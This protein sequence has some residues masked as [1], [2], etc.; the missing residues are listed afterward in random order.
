MKRNKSLSSFI[1]EFLC[2]RDY[3]F[4]YLAFNGFFHNMP[5]DVYLR[6]LYKAMVGKDLD[7]EQ[8]STFNEKLQWLKLFD[9][10]PDY[11]KMVDK[12]LVRQYVIKTIGEKYLIPIVGVW[13]SPDEI[14]FKS[15]PN[16]FVLKCNHNSGTGMCICKD[17]ALL[18]IN[19]VKAE[20]KKGL[21]ED[22]YYQG[23]EWPY[24]DVDR[25]IICEKY[26]T[27]ENDQLSDYKI[28]NFNGVPRVILVCRD[29]FKDSGLTEDFYS[30]K[31]EH[32]DI[33]RPGIPN[34]KQKISKP[35]ELEEMLLL[36]KQLAKNVPFVRTDFYTIKGKVYFGEMTFYPASGLE[37]FEP[38]FIDKQFGDWLE[39]P[40]TK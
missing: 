30:D 4:K 37:K 6:K 15:L 32:L 23:R 10:Q 8:P 14:D 27:D 13:N 36:S 29:R 9:R 35:V 22:Y 38:E 17:K 31:W 26:M 40:N 34:S 5:D 12:Y 21:D 19:K 7:L 11:T 1:K 3:R 18:D 16:Q 39:L 24:K 25:K 20:L 2:N 33:H 28:H